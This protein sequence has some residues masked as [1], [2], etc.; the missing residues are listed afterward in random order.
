VIDV[1]VTPLSLAVLPAELAVVAVAPV[2]PVGA[3]F[4][5]EL[6]QAAAINAT[7]PTATTNL[8]DLCTTATPWLSSTTLGVSP[9]H[10]TRCGLSLNG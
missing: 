9:T 7:A 10:P 4:F 3:A 6:P 5:D 2:A 1:G 8:W